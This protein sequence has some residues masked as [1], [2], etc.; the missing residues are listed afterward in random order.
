MVPVPFRYPLDKTGLSP[1]NKVVGEAHALPNRT[2]RAIAPNYGPF[3]TESLIVRDLAT[4]LPL[5]YGTQFKATE[6]DVFPTGRYGKEIC[7]IILIE[8]QSVSS[9]V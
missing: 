3:Y 1:D 5:T 2:V 7:G 9:N 8:D 4:G 6:L